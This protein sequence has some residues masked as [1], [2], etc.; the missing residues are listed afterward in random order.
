MDELAVADVNASVGRA[1]FICLKKHDVSNRW[2]GDGFPDVPNVRYRPRQ[3]NALLGEQIVDEST[4]VKA[5]LRSFTA[6]N[7]WLAEQLSRISNQ[8]HDIEFGR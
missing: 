2:R 6:P 8:F 7:V 5:N 1:F 3:R 4:A